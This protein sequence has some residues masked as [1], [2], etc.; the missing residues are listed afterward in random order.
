MPISSRRWSSPAA[1]APYADPVSVLG[2]SLRTA[3]ALAGLA[4][5]I[6]DALVRNRDDLLRAL[7]SLPVDPRSA[8]PRLVAS[9]VDGLGEHVVRSWLTLTD[10]AV[11]R[12][13][14]M[15]LG[16]AAGGAATSVQPLVE[17]LQSAFIDPVTKALGLPDARMR[18][19]AIAAMLGGLTVTRQVLCVEPLAS[20]T[21]DDVVAMMAPA[22]DALLRPSSVRL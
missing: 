16:A 20:A 22:V 13:D 8:V 6:V 14:L 4:P 10:D 2:T 12:R 17:M 11:A 19:T 1:T 21:V 9:S 5:G 7:A 18:G 15:A 3:S